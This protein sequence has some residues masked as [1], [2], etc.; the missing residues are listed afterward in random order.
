MQWMS[1][2]PGRSA[3][4]KIAPENKVLTSVTHFTTDTKENQESIYLYDILYD[5]IRERLKENNCLSC[6]HAEECGIPTRDI[7][8]LMALHN[9][10]RN[11]DMAEVKAMK[12]TMQNNK[13]MCDKYYKMVW[14]AVQHLSRIE[15]KLNQDWICLRDRYYQLAFWTVLS[16]ILHDTDSAI[17]DF[18]GVLSDRGGKLSFDIDQGTASG[19]GAALENNIN[20]YPVTRSWEPVC[21][22]Q[23]GTMVELFDIA[24]DKGLWYFDTAVILDELYKP[25]EKKCH[26]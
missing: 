26:I 8:D 21:L 15:E 18:Y 11:G 24:A 7:R 17:L 2:R 20:I 3:L 5:I 10:I 16:I 4:E 13:L 19:D 6:E 9:K 12:Q 22:Y 1:K 14:D 25:E 23:N